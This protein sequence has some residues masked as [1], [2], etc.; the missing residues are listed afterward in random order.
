MEWRISSYRHVMWSNVRTCSNGD[1]SEHIGRRFGAFN[2]FHMVVTIV[3]AAQVLVVV[4]LFPDR[5]GISS[6]DFLAGF[7]GAYRRG[8]A[9]LNIL[10]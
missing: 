8:G 10:Q 7:V 6:G 4:F 9:V 2:T 5:A 1:E 3:A